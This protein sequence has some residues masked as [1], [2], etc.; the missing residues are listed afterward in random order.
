VNLKDAEKMLGNVVKTVEK[1]LGVPIAAIEAEFVKLKDEA[2]A[3]LSSVAHEFLAIFESDLHDAF[4][5]ALADISAALSK[6]GSYI[7]SFSLA[8]IE[9]AVMNTLQTL[10]PE[11]LNILQNLGSALIQGALGLLISK[12]NSPAPVAKPAA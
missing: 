8:D 12:I 11:A 2:V 7:K 3:W 1:D 4:Q 6:M 9:T 5:Q 10:K